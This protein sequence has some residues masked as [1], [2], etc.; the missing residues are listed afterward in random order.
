MGLF[1]KRRKRVDEGLL[2]IETG[3]QGLALAHIQ[4]GPSGTTPRLLRCEYLEGAPETQAELLRQTVID[5]GLSGMPVN[6]LLHPSV[7][8]MFLLESPEVP[9]EELRDAMRWRV[10]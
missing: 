10:K 9:A 8:Q 5:Q 3:P 6:L 1:F 4:R 2:G 7:Y